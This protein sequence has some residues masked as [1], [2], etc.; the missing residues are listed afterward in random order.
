MKAR[1]AEEIGRENLHNQETFPV[2][3]EIKTTGAKIHALFDEIASNLRRNLRNRKVV[4]GNERQK[5]RDRLSCCCFP[6]DSLYS[7][8]FQRSLAHKAYID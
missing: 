7:L 4:R 2:F 5:D 3:N 8:H 6:S 1:Q